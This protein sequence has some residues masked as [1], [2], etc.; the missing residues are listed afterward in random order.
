M[1]VRTSLGI[2]RD[3]GSMYRLVVIVIVDLPSWELE[4]QG[5]QKIGK[6]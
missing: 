1:F 2:I 3:M 5:T 4:V 6:L